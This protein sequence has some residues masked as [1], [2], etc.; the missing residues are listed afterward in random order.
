MDAKGKFND[1]DWEFDSNCANFQHYRDFFQ[2]I[3]KIETGMIAARNTLDAKLSKNDESN[4][5]AGIADIF[6]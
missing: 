6:V 4:A 3:Y 5:I 2:N 1:D